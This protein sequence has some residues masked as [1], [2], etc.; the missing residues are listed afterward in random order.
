M[1]T[2]P[3]KTTVFRTWPSDFLSASRS[4]AATVRTAETFMETRLAA[5]FAPLGA[6]VGAALASAAGADTRAVSALF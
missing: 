3:R 4:S 2:K 6:K 5:P 1:A